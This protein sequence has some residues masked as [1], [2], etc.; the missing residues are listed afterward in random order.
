MATAYIRLSP[1]CI[2]N[3]GFNPLNHTG[4]GLT[5]QNSEGDTASATLV[6]TKNDSEELLYFCDIRLSVHRGHSCPLQS[7]AGNELLE[8]FAAVITLQI[9]YRH[10]PFTSC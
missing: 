8:L 3:L 1:R 9:I 6:V 7:E 10:L 5:S 2:T 4:L